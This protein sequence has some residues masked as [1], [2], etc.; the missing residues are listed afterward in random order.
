MQDKNWIS[1]IEWAI[2]LFTILGMH[3]AMNSRIDS[4]IHEY[5]SKFYELINEIHD[6]RVD[7][8]AHLSVI[9]DRQSR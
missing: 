9:E 4:V 3:Y 1:H 2:L 5:N 7:F 6:E 8:H